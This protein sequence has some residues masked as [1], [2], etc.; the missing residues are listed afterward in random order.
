MLSHYAPLA[1]V[2]VLL[3]RENS[4][5]T[6][7]R[8]RP[9]SSS[10]LTYSDLEN[11][12]LSHLAKDLGVATSSIPNMSSALSAFLTERSIAP[13]CVIASTLRSG[14]YKAR[15]AH[16]SALKSES[17]PVEYIS[18]RKT[19]LNKWRA[20]LV[21]A[22]CRNAAARD[23]PSPFQAA[24]Q[25]LL[26]SKGSAKA[27]ARAAC[28]PPATLQRWLRGAMP[29]KGSAAWIPRLENL[30]G[31]IR[32][33]LTDL[34]PY[35]SIASE[36]S[37]TA[38]VLIP[39]RAM[40][41]DAVRTPYALQD[42]SDS[43]KDEWRD[44]VVYKTTMGAVESEE[45]GEELE[46]HSNG[47]WRLS[48]AKRAAEKPKKWHSFLRGRYVASAGITWSFVSQYLGWLCLS[49]AD[50]APGLEHPDAQTL[51]HLANWTYV[52]KYCDW[53]LTRSDGD[54]HGGMLRFLGIVKSLCNPQTGYLTQS[55]KHFAQKVGLQSLDEWRE[56][57][58]RAYNRARKLHRDYA[59]I[60]KRNRHPSQPLQA[61][62]SRPNPLDEVVDAVKRMESNRPATGGIDEAIWFRDRL[63]LK[64]LASNPIRKENIIGLKYLENDEGHL[65]R[66]GGAWVIHIP[67]E[68]LKN[69]RG[70]AKDRPY[71]MQVQEELWPEIQKYLRVYRPMLAPPSGNQHVFVSSVPSAE[72][73]GSLSR[74]FSALTKRY[75]TSCPG[76][77]VQA[78]RHIVA[79][80]ILK[81]RPNDWSTAAWALHDKE[82][83]VRKEYVH[84]KSDDAQRWFRA[85]MAEPFSRM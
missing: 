9:L 24:L 80:S 11:A 35:R 43:F 42:A 54:V 5:K 16:L 19:L 6:R 56:R 69:A 63:L 50:G 23:E 61:V 81:A 82:E 21:E 25:D 46:R 74:H 13:S 47:Q 71:H 52:K 67:I 72:P 17:R 29:T 75:F 8:K 20:V 34:L 32:G 2:N 7:A 28:M 41:K 53:R 3:P 66:Q 73:W 4:R 14:F 1:S 83:T 48:K 68:E 37:G 57:C 62:L 51:G 31:C 84:L 76:V 58:D 65:R 64:L 78:M 12:F 33:A 27:I 22:D 59:K 85:A 40:L 77:G 79:T 36:G 10:T 45:D 38:P 55:G 44:F 70:A 30:F 49:D 60:S 18:N 39:Y 26:A 15:D